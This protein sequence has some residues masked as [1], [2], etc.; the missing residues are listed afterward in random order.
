[1]IKKLTISGEKPN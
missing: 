1:L